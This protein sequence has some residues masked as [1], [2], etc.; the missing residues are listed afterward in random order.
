MT[1]CQFSSWKQVLWGLVPN[2]RKIILSI[3]MYVAEFVVVTIMDP[4]VLLY[5]AFKEEGRLI[6]LKRRVF[7]YWVKCRQSDGNI[8]RYRLQIPLNEPTEDVE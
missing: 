4:F 2:A 7:Q 1:S 6:Y 3:Y 5:R 8:C